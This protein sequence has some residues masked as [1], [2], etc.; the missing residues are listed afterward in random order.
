MANP[1]VGAVA[2]VLP[3]LRPFNAE[4]P[5]LWFASA[6]FQFNTVAPKITVSETKF[7]YACAA[8]S[9]EVQRQV[10]DIILHPP[11]KPYE[12]LRD[13]LC[14]VYRPSQ[15]EVAARVLDAPMLGDSTATA[16]AADMLQHLL[17]EHQEN[18]VIREAFL[19]RLPLDIRRAIE[20]DE[21][22]NVRNLA[23]AADKR[24]KG[25]VFP[26]ISATPQIVAATGARPKVRADQSQ[27]RQGA[28][29][30]SK[31]GPN[32]WCWIHRKYGSAAM[33][34]AGKCDYPNYPVSV[35]KIQ[36]N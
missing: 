27:K 8:L 9:P 21:T 23:K 6:D 3:K 33:K 18:P 17:P 12:A 35:S 14:D 4:E 16:L 20:S 34:C 5:E 26:Q 31:T 11:A 28:N 32:T 29:S 1:E 2:A 30:S 24:L 15:I 19:R 10:K 7:Q 13:R 25:R 36:E 22:L